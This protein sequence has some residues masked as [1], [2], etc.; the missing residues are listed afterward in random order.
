MRN[1]RSVAPTAYG[2]GALPQALLSFVIFWSAW[3]GIIPTEPLGVVLSAYTLAAGG[4][5]GSALAR[6]P[7]QSRSRELKTVAVVLGR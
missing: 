7:N 1:R 3:T 2:A 4:L 5:A 6:L